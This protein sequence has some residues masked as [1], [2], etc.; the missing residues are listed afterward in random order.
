M[1]GIQF[2]L[3]VFFFLYINKVVMEMVDMNSLGLFDYL[4]LSVQVG[5]TL[6]ILIF[7]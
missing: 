7:N 5:F 1:L 6:Q 3:T 4:I 2:S